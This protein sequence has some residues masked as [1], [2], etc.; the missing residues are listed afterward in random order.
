[1]AI[2]FLETDALTIYNSVMDQLTDTVGEPLYS[3]DERRIYGE[4][5]AMVLMAV[6]NDLNDA[7]K[8]RLLRYARGE[9]LDELGDRV[10]VKRI[11]PTPASDIFR[12]KV[13]EARDRNVV[14]P[15]GTRVTQD[16]IIYFA[17]DQIAIIESGNLYV[18][19]ECTC[20][21]AGEAYN[22]LP[23]NSITILVDKIPYIASVTNLY[24]TS[25]GDDGEAYTEDGDSKFRERIRL[26]PASFSVAGPME[27]YKYYALSADSRIVDAHI[28]FP[29][30]CVVDIYPLMMGG[31]IPSAEVL[32]TVQ[33]VFTDDIRPMT[34]QVT[35]KAPTQVSYDI[36]VKYYCTPENEE[37][38]IILVENEGAAIDNYIDW[39]SSALGRDISPDA[40][41]RQILAPADDDMLTN[42]VER[43]DIISPAFK[44]LS[45]SQVAKFSGKLTVSHEVIGG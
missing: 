9:T 30:A 27:A 11:Q 31:Q 24:G 41:R 18:D 45:A 20:I 33:S 15:S 26:A 23:E 13:S 12:F 5:V 22:D 7:A 34:D 36:N 35:V 42:R 38:A 1:M 19:V 6:Y 8:Q 4:A 3:G 16:G 29:A 25:G 40:L 37:A 32:E 2:S 17:T 21:T 39:Q 14:I 43:V 28:D 44:E 10:G